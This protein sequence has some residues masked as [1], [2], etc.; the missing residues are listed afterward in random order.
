[1]NCENF[2]FEKMSQFLKSNSKKDTDTRSE[3][4]SRFKNQFINVKCLGIGGFGVV[5]K[6]KDKDSKINYAIKQIGSNR[7]IGT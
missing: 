7:T 4:E 2:L 6:V 3:T 1:M 5:F